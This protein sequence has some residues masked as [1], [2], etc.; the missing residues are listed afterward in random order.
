M[1]LQSFYIFVVSNDKYYIMPSGDLHVYSVSKA[2]SGSRYKC[3]IINRL[4]SIVSV[5]ATAGR[6]FVTGKIVISC[7]LI[8]YLLVVFSY[9][10]SVVIRGG[11]NGCSSNIRLFFLP[12][13]CST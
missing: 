1:G 10:Y 5:S 9:S 6:L 4:S 8:V 13:T 11:R 7:F 2:E 12:S 3:K